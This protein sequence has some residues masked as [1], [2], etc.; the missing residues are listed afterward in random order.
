MNSDEPR[1]TVDQF[2]GPTHSKDARIPGTLGY[3]ALALPALAI[4]AD[5]VFAIVRGWSVESRLDGAVVVV[6]AVWLLATTALWALPAGRGLY[7]RRYAQLILLGTSGCIAWLMAELALGGIVASVAEPFHC[8]RPG[9]KV[10]YRPKTGVMRDVGSEAR[11]SFNAWGVRGRELPQRSAAYRIVCLGGSSTACTYLDDAKTWPRLL[12]SDL[13]AADP[14][15]GYWVGNAAIPGFKSPEHRR[16]V[17][18]SALIGEIDCLVVQAGINDFAAVLAGP[19]PAPPWWSR[20]RV[21]QLVRVLS[22]QYAT[23]GTLVEDTAGTV[24]LR[25]RATR[26]AAEISSRVP[27]LEPGLQEFSDNLRAI[28]ARCN[29]CNMRVVFTTQPVLWRDDL[30]ADNVAL[31]WFGQLP[32]G[33]FLSVDKLRAGMDLYNQALRSVC[34]ECGAELIDLRQLDGDPAVFYDDCHFTETGAR[35]VARLIA[36]WFVAHPVPAGKEV[37]P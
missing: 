29:N 1:A 26:Q 20:S 7:N 3:V 9:L 13:Q 21:L 8:W 34:A 24:Y 28:I 17:E 30:D 18:E 32:D 22:R 37:A 35:R 10:V 31:L 33:R 15:R 19:R 23:S 27:A 2:A 6:A 14:S 25:R 16:F 12:E 36:D 5:A 4:L 11:V